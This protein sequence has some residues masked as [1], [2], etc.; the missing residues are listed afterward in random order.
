MTDFDLLQDR[1]AI[2]EA[3]PRDG[4]LM[5]ADASEEEPSWE[6]TFREMARNK[7]DGWNRG[8]WRVPLA[9]SGQS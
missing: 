6:Q 4:I 8:S 7:E 1:V 5:K 2:V 3:S 9:G